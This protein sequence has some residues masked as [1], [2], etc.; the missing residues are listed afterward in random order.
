MNYK[1]FCV[2][3][4]LSTAAF[5]GTDLAN[6]DD[7]VLATDSHYSG[8]MTVDE[9]YGNYDTS[10]INSGYVSLE[11]HSEGNYASWGGF[12]IS[13][14]IDTTTVGYENQYSVYTGA[15]QS[16]SNFAVGYMDSFNDYNPTMILASTMVVD[17][18]YLT[19]TTYTALDMLNGS[20]YSKKFGGESGDDEDWL[21]VVIEGFDANGNSTATVDFYLADFRFADNAL[22]YIVDDWELIDLTSLGQVKSL[23]FTMESS[24]TGMFGMNTPSY[25]AM[26]TVVP[27]PSTMVLLGLGALVLRR[28]RA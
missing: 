5:A 13:N 21:K 12:A 14:E 27:E 6:F 28:K 15:A 8:N 4:V 16:G 19:N 7:Y 3:C 25:F 10:Y 9:L 18:L 11:N 2:I 17:E 1:M 22:D 24:D 26:D 20:A 23:V